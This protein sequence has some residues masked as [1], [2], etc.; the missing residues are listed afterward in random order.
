[1]LED[2]FTLGAVKA[3]HRAGLFGTHVDGLTEDLS[4]D[5]Y[6]RESVRSA[7][8]AVRGFGRWMDRRDLRVKDVSE[9]M[10]A[11]FGRRRRS[12]IRRGRLAALH[13][14]LTRLRRLGLA[15]LRLQP[16]GRP[17]ERIER[18]FATFLRSERALSTATV[19]NYCPVAR[20]FMVE[21]FA[22]GSVDLERLCAVDIHEFILRRSRL[23]RPKR[24][25]LTL[26]ALRSFLRFLYLRG[27]IA[28]PLADHIPAVA[29]WRLSDPPNWLSADAIKQTLEC[30]DRRSAT[31]Q[32]NYAILILLA[33]LG[34]RA[35]EIVSMELDDIRWETGEISVCGKGPQRKRFPLPDD[36]G[37]AVATYLKNGRPSCSSRRVFLRTRAPYRGLGNSSSLD[38]IVSRALSRAGI[39]PPNKGAHLFRHSLATN[40]L[41][42][43]ATL[44]EIGQILHHKSPNTTAIYAK[45]DLSGLRAL[46]Q[47]WPGEKT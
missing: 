40:M 34:L 37:R 26:T 39:D 38:A 25:Q 18:D 14:L 28:T 7:I 33:R 5:G 24:M 12:W 10:I 11:E 9:K 22:A 41:H 3:R 15:P 19:T 35:G 4:T 43:G 27:R 45:V 47:P 23:C 29:C 32:R 20:L 13:A 2:Y 46:A 1:M 16:E 30:C 36:V 17:I 6:A 8:V 31:G 44:T 42:N 21:R